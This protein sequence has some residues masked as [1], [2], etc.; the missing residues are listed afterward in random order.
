[1]R[2]SSYSLPLTMSAVAL[3]LCLPLIVLSQT[4][5]KFVISAK[6]GGINAVTGNASVHGRGTSEWEQLT[7]KEDLEAGDVV[8]TDFDGRVEMLLNPGSYLR[9]GENS[10]FELI[11]NSLENLE[12]RLARGTAIV[13][14][15][16]FDG[17]EL[18]IN[19]STPDT[20]LAIVRGGL[21]RVSVVP[22][23]STELIVRKGRVLLSDSGTKIK[24]GNKVV[25]TSGSVAIAKLQK[26][27]KKRVDGLD[28]WSKERAQTVA[29]ANNKVRRRDVNL[30]LAS[31]DNR[32]LQGRTAGF[33]YYNS[34]F[35]C[36]TFLPFYYRWGWSSPYGA[37]YSNAIFGNVWGTGG[38][39]YNADGRNNSTPS[40]SVPGGGSRSGG[41]GG[42]TRPSPQAPRPMP[43]PGLVGPSPGP[44][45]SPQAA[46]GRVERRS[47]VRIPEN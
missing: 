20:K 41:Y 15:T 17:M 9:V 30:L 8:K 3:V 16:G 19:I 13:E 18:S 36:Y 24:G 6:A 32:W 42:N 29:K 7:I 45:E 46:P 26:A 39:G 27:E 23:A 12:V 25:F 47:Y 44:R 2:K 34:A 37:S 21:Y 35:R 22:G 31:V 14:A 10:E 1:M 38:Y 33:W 11:S 4:R 28:T 43:G 40:G 5:D